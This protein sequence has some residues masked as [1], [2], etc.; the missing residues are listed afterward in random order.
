MKQ[1]VAFFKAYIALG[2]HNKKALNENELTQIYVEQAQIFIRKKELPFNISS[3]YQDIYNKSKGFSDLYFYPNE[4]GNS[5][6]SLFSVECKR[7]P[8]PVTS[9][10]KEYVFGPTNNGGIE[11]YKTEKHGKGFK[12][13]GLIGFIEKETP[14]HWLKSI[15][16]WIKDISNT[17][18]N[19][20]KDEILTEVESIKDYSFLKSVAHR[21]SDDIKLI[22]LWINLN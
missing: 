12:T 5:N 15:N 14:K 20:Q 22:H 13:C 18:S 16:A 10:E 19:W 4:L 11:R 6:S 7:L 17:N 8:S 3:Q 1:N 9:R 2:Y 21:K